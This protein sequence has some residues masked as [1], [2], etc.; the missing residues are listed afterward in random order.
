MEKVSIFIHPNR[1]H[2]V[3][4]NG[5]NWGALILPVHWAYS[6][7]MAKFG[8][9]LIA[10]HA[11]PIGLALAAAYS[12]DYAVISK[13]FLCLA[14]LIYFSM[15]LFCGLYGNRLKVKEL[16]LNGFKRIN[17]TSSC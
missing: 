13:M 16:E 17:N 8:G 1:D 9:K 4:K 12:A 7:G 14:I 2:R 11:I 3:V 15:H 5:F 10:F 6:E